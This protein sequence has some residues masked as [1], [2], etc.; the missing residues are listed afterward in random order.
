[1]RATMRNEVV[2]SS[3]CNQGRKWA[4]ALYDPGLP[5]ISRT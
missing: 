3:I 5:G 1:M 2:N 4:M